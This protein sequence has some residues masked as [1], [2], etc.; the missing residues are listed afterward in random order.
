MVDPPRIPAVR[1]HF[2]AIHDLGHLFGCLLCNLAAFGQG[3]D[4]HVHLP[5]GNGILPSRTDGV[6]TCYQIAE[7]QQTIATEEIRTRPQAGP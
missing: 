5:G 1:V 7:V 6:G 2:A 4:E 3:H